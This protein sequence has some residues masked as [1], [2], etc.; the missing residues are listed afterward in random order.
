M[1]AA[2]R[3]V[4]LALL[5]AVPACQILGRRS[6]DSASC[7]SS[8]GLASDGTALF[9]ANVADMQDGVEASYTR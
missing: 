5:V 3:G 7:G 8:D 2:I 4:T 9:Y 6:A 1:T